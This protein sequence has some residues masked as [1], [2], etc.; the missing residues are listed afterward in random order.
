MCYLIKGLSEMGVENHVVFRKGSYLH[1]KCKELFE[2]VRCLPLPLKGEFDLYSSKVISRYVD[3]FSIDI[4]HC[5][6]SHAHTIAYFSKVLSKRKPKVLVTRRVD[7]DIYAK[8][9]FRLLSRIKYR[10]MADHYIAISKRVRDVMVSRGVDPRKISIVYSGVDPSDIPSDPRPDEL[11]K[12][13]SIPDGVKVVGNIAHIAPHKHHENL[14]VAFKE[15][16]GKRSDVFLV[17]VGGGERLSD[18]ISL[19]R[20][21]GISDNVVFTGFREDAKRFFSMFDL[22]VVSSREEGLCT[23]I[24]DAFVSCVP[25]VATDAGGIPELV[26]DMETGVLARKEDPVALSR[27]ILWALEHPDSMMKM[28]ERAK[29]VALKN[30]TVERMIEGNYKV[31]RNILYGK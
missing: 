8:S 22:F 19:S 17:V 27:A 9:S 16:L 26:K 7:F 20:R 24:V 30:F 14:L 5:H 4:L 3:R 29:E 23:S 28:A 18:L 12:E 6:T 10:Y 31:Y 1:E 2:G 25:V 15:V 21:L 11:R 13:F